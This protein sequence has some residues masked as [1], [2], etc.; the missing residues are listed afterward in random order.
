[1]KTL[2]RINIDA[3]CY[4]Y[5]HNYIQKN[6]IANRGRF[7]GNKQN[8]FVGMLGQICF[9]KYLYN[10]LPVLTNGFDNGYDLMHDGCTIDIKTMQRK[11]FMRPDYVNNFVALQ[12]NY[13]CDVLVFLN[14]VKEFELLGTIEICGWIFKKELQS[15][16]NYY[17]AGTIRQR[18]DKTEFSLK[19]DLYEIPQSKLR[20]WK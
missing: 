2:P 5:A 17:K 15:V 6:N 12:I 20:Y 7:D 8:Q 11:G 10:E 16:A 19:E 9:Y 14:Y 18:L 13:E 4:E 3:E 1:M